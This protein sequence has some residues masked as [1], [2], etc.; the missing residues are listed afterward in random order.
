[1]TAV[2]PGGNSA[3]T[4]IIEIIIS[5]G[6]LPLQG[7]KLFVIIAISLSRGES[8]IR[9]DIIPAALQPKPMLIVRA[10]LPCAP[11]FLKSGSRLNATLGR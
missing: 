11:T 10:C 7:T 2:S 6:N 5:V 4:N 3:A 9:V 8:M 1:M